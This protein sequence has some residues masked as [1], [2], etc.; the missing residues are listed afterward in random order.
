MT[1][2]EKIPADDPPPPPPLPT[3]LGVG[4]VSDTAATETVEPAQSAPPLSPPFEVE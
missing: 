2:L 3:A 1:K 4:A